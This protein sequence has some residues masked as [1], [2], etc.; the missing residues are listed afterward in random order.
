M[1][2]NVAELGRFVLGQTWGFFQIQVPGFSFTFGQM[3]FGIAIC[4]VSI[5]VLRVFFGIG[6]KGVIYRAA[7]SRRPKISENRKGDEY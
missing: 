3:L 7:S 5:L 4:S 1:S 2:E 6:G